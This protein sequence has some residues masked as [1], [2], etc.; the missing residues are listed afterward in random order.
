M[1]GLPARFPDGTLCRVKKTSIYLEP[2]HDR[3]LARRAERE[4]ITKA[5]LIR[6]TLR[7]ALTEEPRPRITAIGIIE[8]PGDVADNVDRYL[9]EGFGRD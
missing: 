3:T 9:A 5:E 6:L 2:E 4:G 7:R 8:G 1:P